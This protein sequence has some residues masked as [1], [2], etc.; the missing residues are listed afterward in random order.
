MM[1]KA[2]LL[3]A[4]FALA[5]NVAYPQSRSADQ[6][7]QL[8]AGDVIPI[9]DTL[10]I[11]VMR[12]TKAFEGIKIKG[13]AMVVVLEMEAGKKGATLFYKLN[14]NASTSEI[15]L[16]SGARRVAPCAVMEDFPSW[17]KDNDKDV[18]SLDPKETVGGTTLTFQQKGS[19]AL[20]FDVPLE[21]AKAPKKL[22]VALRMVQ[23]KDEQRSFVVSL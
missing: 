7:Q 4:V 13:E 18:D 9:G 20:L 6:A 5:I 22:S 11:K 19:I 17:G 2:L 16:L 8:K 14:A 23:P 1:R 21:D 15:Y 10:F 12:A 3:A